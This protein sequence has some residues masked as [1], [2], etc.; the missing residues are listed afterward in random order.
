[1]FP[2]QNQLAN[3]STHPA[4][5]RW[6]ERTGRYK[7]NEKWK[8][9]DC[10]SVGGWW[11]TDFKC[12]AHTVWSVCALP[13]CFPELPLPIRHRYTSLT[14]KMNLLLSNKKKTKHNLALTDAHIIGKWKAWMNSFVRHL[15]LVS[16]EWLKSERICWLMKKKKFNDDKTPGLQSKPLAVGVRN[17]EL[18]RS[19]RNMGVIF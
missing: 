12:T 3:H 2:L 17:R 1:M 10:V 14:F 18:S 9:Q 5:G 16:A 13:P 11:K 19:V 4:L 7:R 6:K 15:L 8:Q